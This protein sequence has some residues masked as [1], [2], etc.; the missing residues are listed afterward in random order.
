[1]DRQAFSWVVRDVPAAT[2]A[3]LK[4]ST[5]PSKGISRK[6]YPVVNANTCVVRRA[7]GFDWESSPRAEYS[8]LYTATSVPNPDLVALDVEFGTV[9]EFLEG[10]VRPRFVLGQ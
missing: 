7:R 4:N 5:D 6:S 8:G 9:E 3:L 2:L 10:E 1:M